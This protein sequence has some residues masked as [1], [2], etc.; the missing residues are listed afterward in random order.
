MPRPIRSTRDTYAPSAECEHCPFCHVA[1]SGQWIKAAHSRVVGRTG[2]R[3]RVFRR[4]PFCK[5]KFGA[6]ALREHVPLCRKNPRLAT[7]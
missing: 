4:C 1:L 3:P 5:E 7:A 6:R 2:G